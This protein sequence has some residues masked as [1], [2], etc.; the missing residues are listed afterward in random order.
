M[1][2]EY[3]ICSKINQIINGSDLTH[4]DFLQIVETFN[5]IE[6]AKHLD[7]SGWFDFKMKLTRLFLAYGYKD[8]WDISKNKIDALVIDE[9]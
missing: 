1:L 6:K 9:N 8:N 3:K 7:G 5:T 4:E 2:P